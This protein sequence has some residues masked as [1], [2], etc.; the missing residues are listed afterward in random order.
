MEAVRGTGDGGGGSPRA[1]TDDSARLAEIRARA[2]AATDGPWDYGDQSATIHA[3]SDDY[4]Q[5]AHFMSEPGAGMEW[6]MDQVRANAQFAAAAR[7][8]VPFLLDAI[9]ARDT[10]IESLRHSAG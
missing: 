6:D 10:E 5:V 3:P 4:K 2:D 7:S 1:M 8:D 9:A